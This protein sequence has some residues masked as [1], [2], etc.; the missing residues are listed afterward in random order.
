M[1]AQT[2]YLRENRVPELID[3]LI[4]KLV[5]SRPANPRQFLA[6]E[7]AT[8]SS[9]GSDVDDFPPFSHDSRRTPVAIQNVLTREIFHQ[10]KGRRTALGVSLEDCI[11]DGLRTHWNSKD[12]KN[13]DEEADKAAVSLGFYPGD[14][15]SLTLFEPIADGVLYERVRSAVT[16]K[17]GGRRKSA[18]ESAVSFVSSLLPLR[19]DTS[20]ANVQVGYSLEESMCLAAAVKLRRNVRTFH[21]APSMSRGELIGLQTLMHSHLTQAMTKAKQ[22]QGQ[23]TRLFEEKPLQRKAS[24]AGNM[25]TPP[26]AAHNQNKARVLNL[27]PQPSELVANVRREWPSTSGYYCSSDWAVVVAVGTKEEHVEISSLALGNNLRD[28][29]ERV[30]ELSN[31]LNTSL[32][33]S[34]AGE[35]GSTNSGLR[36]MFSDK[37]GGYVTCNLEYLHSGLSFVF[38]LQLPNLLGYPQF[39]EILEKLYLCRQPNVPSP[40]WSDTG[41]ATVESCIPPLLFT[42]SEQ[43]QLVATNVNVLLDMES[44]LDCGASIDKKV[45]LLLSGASQ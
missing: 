36:W 42:P 21:L 31:I 2:L 34:A 30:H 15:E 10:L 37:Y 22:F 39:Q 27:L 16:A 35:A 4:C 45:E 12:D 9:H 26:G 24:S 38:V 3:G 43:L 23:Y 13:K 28:A 7:L 32:Q 20:I 1:D 18:T 8:R 14:E 11:A 19:H 33:N 44:T 40:D 41:V 6:D 25:C 17:S 29:F 5:A